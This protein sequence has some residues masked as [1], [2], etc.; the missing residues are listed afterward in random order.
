VIAGFDGFLFILGL[1]LLVVEWF[2]WEVSAFGRE[3]SDEN[4][5]FAQIIAFT[6]PRQPRCA[7]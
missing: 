5:E 4:Q 7:P 6:S 3:K 2:F 1:L